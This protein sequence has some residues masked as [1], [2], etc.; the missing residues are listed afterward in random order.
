MT[1]R[2]PLR[3]LQIRIFRRRLGP[4]QTGRPPE[5]PTLPVLPR[6]HEPGRRNVSPDLQR[7][8]RRLQLQAAHR[9]KGLR[10]VLRRILQ[11]G[12]RRCKFGVL[13]MFLYL[14]VFFNVMASFTYVLSIIQPRQGLTSPPLGF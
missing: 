13:K 1:G 4:S 9:R 7:I 12:Q 8:H 11:S 2:L 3:T 6:G 10:Q 5:L 14:F